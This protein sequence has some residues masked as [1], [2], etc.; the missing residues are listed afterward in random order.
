[1]TEEIKREILAIRDT[2][3]TNMLDVP[4]VQRIAYEMEFFDLVCFIE[5]HRKEYIHFIFTGE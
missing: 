5:E 2:A 3:R 1:M 4:M